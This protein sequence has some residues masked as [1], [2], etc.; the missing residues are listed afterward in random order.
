MWRFVYGSDT[1]FFQQGIKL[2][3]TNPKSIIWSE[4]FL[5]TGDIISK[6]IEDGKIATMYRDNYYKSLI[7]QI[8]F[9]AAFEGYKCIVCN[10]A[11][12]SSQLFDSVKDINKYDLLISF[13]FDGKQYVISLYTKKD[14]D[15][16]T[17]AM[18]YG[19]GGHKQ[20]SGFVTTNYPFN[21]E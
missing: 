15:V 4:L 8:S 16:S 19:G 5:D 14:I 18:K 12:V 2:L 21:P 20:A 6:T 13:Y 11:F 9:D 1:N 3:F 7:D 10:A 17:I